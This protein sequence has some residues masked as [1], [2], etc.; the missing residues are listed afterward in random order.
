MMLR[1]LLIVLSLLLIVTGAVVGLLGSEAGSRWLLQ[2]A[3]TAVPGTASV[4][5]IEGRLLDRIE[6]TGLQYRS[7]TQTAAID[8]LVF[9]WKAVQLLRGTL[10]IEA[11]AAQGIRIRLIE[12]GKE[13]PSAP[14]QLPDRLALPIQIVIRNFLVTDA[15]LVQGDQAYRLDS[16]QLSARTEDDTLI[17][18]FLKL[19]AR[20][21]AAEAQGRITLDH[22]F[23]LHLTLDWR[24]L[25]WPLAGAQP[26]VRSEQGTLEVSGKLV[27]YRI[28]LTGNLAHPELPESGLLFQGKGNLDSMN[29][30]ALE[31]KSK[32]GLFRVHGDVSWKDV[33]AFDVNAVLRNFNPAIVLPDLPGSLT[34]A[35]RLKGRLEGETLEL[36]A[37][38]E[39]L[40]GQLRG[41]PLEG[42]GRLRLSGSRLKIDKLRLVSGAN[43][44]TADGTLEP[45]QSDFKIDLNAPNLDQLWPGLGGSLKVHGLLEGGWQNPTVRLQATGKHLLFDRHQA[46]RI[47]VD[48]DYHHEANRI[49]KLDLSASAIQSGDLRIASLAIKGSG[50]QPRHQLTAA[51]QS[52][53]GDL[54][55][56]LAGSLK[57]AT[58]RGSLSRLDLKSRD[59]GQ[60]QLADNWHIALTRK[61][62]GIDA[63]IEKGCLIRKEASLCAAGNYR[64]EGDFDMNLKLSEVPLAL[65][66]PVL[67]EG[68]A[69]SGHLN[70]DADM[71]RQRNVLTGRYQVTLPSGSAITFQTEQAPQRFVLGASSLS[72]KIDGDTVS[73]DLD[74]ALPGRDYLRGNLR[75]NTG[76]KQALSGRVAASM[77]EFDWIKPFVPRLTDIKADLK[78]DLTLSGTPAKPEVQGMVRL[79][80]GAV[81]IAAH[82]ID[83]IDVEAVTGEMPDRIRIQGSLKA[84]GAPVTLA[85]SYE[86]DGDYQFALNAPGIPLNLAQPYLP[87]QLEIDG[88]V[89]ADAEIRQQRGTMRGNYRIEMSAGTRILAKSQRPSKPIS[90]GTTLLTGT[91]DNRTI[92][93]DLDMAL[94]G[95]D[96]VRGQLRLATA[97]PQALDGRLNASIAELALLDAFVPQLANV[98]GRLHADLTLRGTTE[99]PIVQGSAGLADAAADVADLGLSL[100][101]INLDAATTDE[102][103]RRLRIQGF[104][105]SGQ[106]VI[107]LDGFARL[108]PGWPVELT[109]IGEKFEAA[110]LPEAE[111]SVSPQ[112]KIAFGN[113]QGSVTGKVK[114]A[115]ADIEV[116]ELPA[117]SVKVSEDEIIVGQ[118]ET[119]EA[120]APIN[121]HANIEVDLGKDTHFSGFGLETDLTGKLQI[122]QKDQKL[123]LHGNVDMKEATY[124]SYGQDLTVRKGRFVFNGPPDNP[125]LDVE[126]I[127][128][129]RDKKVTAVLALTGP[130]KS[131]KTKISSDPA[132]PESEALAYLVT[133]RSMSQV[134]KDEGNMIAAAALSYGTGQ[135]SWLADKLGIDEF[136]VKE[137]ETLQDTL[138]A[139][140]QYLNP[141]F[142]VGAK[143]GLFNNQAALVLKR[144]LTE[145]LNV[146]TEA[147]VSQRIK[148]NYERN[149]D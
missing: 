61:P 142:Y 104:A 126:A 115:N 143:V 9:D 27:D 139:V 149:V 3:L 38:L 34:L 97:A 74:L 28:K 48:V 96:F 103:G 29:I 45:G 41:H 112:L 102:Q 76:R 73:A 63:R 77:V 90:L 13:E 54:Q 60:W 5:T 89:L 7:E 6:L 121:I 4:D 50:T 119:R 144:K 71:R 47:T 35:T 10:D 87:E 22:G 132:L 116:K 51:V 107:N 66:Q 19:D 92:S 91:L 109:L 134:S 68:M 129:S 147:G 137:G 105:Q 125:W 70:G 122:V 93:A 85:G 15:E 58:W 138:V 95:K 59:W 120:A 64:A 36:D 84:D 69:V 44:L 67:P 11:F 42:E 110:K 57:G 124:K 86:F 56:A 52:S 113:G 94:A 1:V 25:Q 32:E 148:L 133:G 146:E 72:G 30:E 31:L 78:A 14:L 106:G 127:R 111:V 2:Q 16:L 37:V 128:V 108:E 100:R 49:S 80:D 98:K 140:G 99:T 130:A 145:S 136:E 55:A 18:S 117:G 8:R 23:P 123:R 88:T 118:E 24:D 141:D 75:L 43:R 12:T 53:Y 131:P 62:A 135:M 21:L 40:T 82:R 114:V 33:P 81:G 101:K 17:L 39:Q 20:P 46:E 83:A 26:Q 65:T 79:S